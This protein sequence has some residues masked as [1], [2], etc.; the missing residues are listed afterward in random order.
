MNKILTVLLCS[1]LSVQAFA[2]SVGDLR[3]MTARNPQGVDATPEFYW[4][5]TSD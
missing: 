5:P 2:L 4:K 3:V 1:L